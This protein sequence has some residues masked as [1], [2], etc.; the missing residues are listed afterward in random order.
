MRDLERINP[1]PKLVWF[2]NYAIDEVTARLSNKGEH[3]EWLAWA[4]SWKEGRHSPATCVDI[5]HHCFKD[6]EDSVQHCL[7]Q[8]AWGAKEACYNTPASGWLVIRYIADALIAFGVAFPNNEL[9]LISKK[10]WHTTS[11]LTS[12]IRRKTWL[13]PLN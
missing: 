9:R 5:A 2:I 10:T 12:R 6:K 13:K 7:G 8:I 1:N 3:G 11:T 4:S